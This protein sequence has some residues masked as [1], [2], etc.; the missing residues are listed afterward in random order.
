MEIYTSYMANW[1]HFGNC[2]PISVM[3]YTPKYFEGNSLRILAPPEK[4][5]LDYRNKK[6]TFS[7]YSRLYYD[8]LVNYGF[9]NIMNAISNISHG[10][11]VVLLCT[12]KNIL[13]CHRLILASFIE[14]N[15]TLKVNELPNS[16]DGTYRV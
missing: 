8:F 5:F 10:R 9:Q 12:C 6:I 1:R 11:D 2:V 7:E 15:S 4:V 16:N 3:R 14:E 13:K